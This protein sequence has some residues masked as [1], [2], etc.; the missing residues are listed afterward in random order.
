MDSS[1]WVNTSLGL[2]LVPNHSPHAM[3]LMEDEDQPP[4]STSSMTAAAAT[5][6]GAG[7][8]VLLGEE[9]NRI[10]L[11]NK[12]LTEMLT[13]LCQNY[14]A[15]EAHVK[16][17]AS[18]NELILANNCLIKKRKAPPLDGTIGFTRNATSTTAET[19]FSDEE[20]YKRPLEMSSNINLKISRVCV[21]TDV[22]DTRLIVKDGYQW[23]KYGQKVTRD[24]PSPRAYY[25]CSF[26]PTCPVKKK[27]QKSAENPCLLVA[28]Y[29]GEHNHN[30]PAQPQVIT[31]DHRQG[32]N[33]ITT[34]T[35]SIPLVLDDHSSNIL[36]HK[37]SSS[38]PTT[39]SMSSSSDHN[40]SLMEPG[41]SCGHKPNQ[42]IE[43]AADHHPQYDHK[44]TNFQQLLVQQMASSL[45][46]DPN[47][48]TALAAAIAAGRF[49]PPIPKW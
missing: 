3:E 44:A 40:S 47:F 13:V 14:N 7:G 48:T 35:T 4:V 38:S 41:S 31:I 21:P 9:L 17:L 6:V 16:E 27:V 28:T 20:S 32:P 42:V 19:S 24:N 23:R 34:T 46:K 39:M 11:E 29:E 18:E 15:L 5:A 1:K 25:K 22:S 49:N 30:H 26:A 33:L 10:S 37:R 12:K 43:A 36:A 2:S 45:T 8:S